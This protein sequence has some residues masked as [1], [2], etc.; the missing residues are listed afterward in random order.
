MGKAKG[1]A[2]GKKGGKR[3]GTPKTGCYRYS[4]P[5]FVQD[6]LARGAAAVAADALRGAGLESALR[7]LRAGGFVVDIGAGLGDAV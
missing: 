5:H 1:K 4:G 2:T 7:H 3:K 6:A